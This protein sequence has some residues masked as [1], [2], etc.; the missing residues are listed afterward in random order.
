MQFRKPKQVDDPQTNVGLV[1]VS[2]MARI[3]GITRQHLSDLARV[4]RVPT[5]I[6]RGVRRYDVDRILDIAPECNLPLPPLRCRGT[7]AADVVWAYE[8]LGQGPWNVPTAPSGA[9]WRLYLDAKRD[10]MFR[11][12]LTRIVL[13]LA[14]RDTGGGMVPGSTTEG[15]DSQ[16]TVAERVLQ[17][18]DFSK[19]SGPLAVTIDNHDDIYGY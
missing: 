3:L 10:R 6:V 13:K 8:A 15:D 1:T 16:L 14:E 12:H 5:T 2:P 18:L 11:R 7:Y 4:G 19:V 17:T 9:G